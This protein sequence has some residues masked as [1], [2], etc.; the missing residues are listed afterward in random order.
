MSNI[1]KPNEPTPITVQMSRD[2]AKGL[3]SILAEYSARITMP[4]FKEDMTEE[5]K[6]EVSNVFEERKK[7]SASIANSLW[8]EAN[9]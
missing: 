7:F 5:Q 4:D 1:I 2:M 3:A 9:K 8:S 6:T